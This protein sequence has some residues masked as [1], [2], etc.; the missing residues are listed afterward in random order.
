MV[1]RAHFDRSLGELSNEILLMGNRVKRELDLALTALV[2]LNTE[3]ARQVYDEDKLVN[4]ARFEIEEKCFTLI[5]TQQ[6]AARDLRV[7]V[8]AMNM[9]VDLERMGDQAKGIAKL[10]PHLRLNP[11]QE[12]PHELGQMGIMVGRMLED[13]LTAFADEN[14]KLARSVAQRDDDVDELYARVFTKVMNRM[15]EVEN[16][17]NA[18]AAYEIL[19]AA[20]ELE[21]FGDLATNI[22]ERTIYLVTGSLDEINIDD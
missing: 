7:I 19:R 11:R 2:E 18:E 5:V 21:R 10:I 4:Q 3:L 15:T 12:Q 1:T 20:R 6:P 17:N 9:I 22:A 16:T 13:T 14:V 8:A